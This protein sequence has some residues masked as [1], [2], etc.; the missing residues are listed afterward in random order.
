MRIILAILFAWHAIGQTVF[1]SSIKESGGDYGSLQAWEASLGTLDLVALNRIY[2]AS[3]EGSWS[4]PDTTAFTISG[5]VTGPNNYLVI[6]NTSSQ[7]LGKP[8]TANAYKLYVSNPTA[9]LYVNVQYMRIYG[10]HVEVHSSTADNRH[11][12]WVNLSSGGSEVHIRDCFLANDPGSTYQSFTVNASDTD[13]GTIYIV[14]CIHWHRQA[15]NAAVY[16]ISVSATNSYV[17][18][19]TVYALKGGGISRNAGTAVAVNN[20]VVDGSGAS[21][22]CYNGTFTSSDYNISLDATSTGGAHDKTNVTPA[23][24][25]A[26]N[27]D[28]STKDFQIVGRGTADPGSGWYSTDTAGSTRVAPWDVGAFE[29]ANGPYLIGPTINIR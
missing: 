23:F 6:T 5:P 16:A 12:V 10:V 15:K 4:G 29:F 25:D 7:H 13:I 24:T 1:P 14:N 11:P 9:G 26:A 19:N 21:S 2:I 20:I 27:G 8:N 22:S 3:I 17:W 18:N 28:F